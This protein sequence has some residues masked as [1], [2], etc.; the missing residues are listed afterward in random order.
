MTDKL[1]EKNPYI[2]E[3]DARVTE[4]EAKGDIYRICLDRSAFFPEGG[5]QPGDRGWLGDAVISDTHEKAGKVWHY[6][7]RPLEIGSEVRGRL[8]WAFRYSNMQ[9]HAGEHIVSGLIHGKYGYDN[10]GFH[11]GSEAIT[12]DINGELTEEQVREIEMKA[13]QAI[14]E[15]VPIQGGHTSK[16]GACPNELSK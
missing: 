1:Y 8:D 14:Q 10:V 11:M 2:R 16:G 3:F 9:N 13:N 4:C 15:N 7:D 5:G 12:L 6:A